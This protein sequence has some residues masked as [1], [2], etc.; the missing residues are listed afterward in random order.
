MI[1]IRDTWKSKKGRI[2]TWIDVYLGLGAEKD[3]KT[4]G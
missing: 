1:C 4:G 3:G 2:K